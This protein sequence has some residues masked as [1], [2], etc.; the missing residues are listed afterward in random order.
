MN[1]QQHLK[2]LKIGGKI[3]ENELEF[4]TVAQTFANWENPKILVHG[5][6]RKA[7]TVAK[8]L[9]ITPKMHE[10][11][12]ITDDATLEV[13]TMVYAGWM[14]KK[15]VSHLQALGCNALGLSGADLNSIQAHKRIVES[16]DY[17]WAGDI[18]AI[19]TKALLPLLQLAITPVFCAITHDNK[20][21]LLNTNAD[22]IAAYL[23]TALATFYTVQ[24]H[25]C[26]DKA[27]VLLDAADDTS[28]I[29]QINPESYKK[30][31]LEGIIAGGM[32]PKLDNAFA[33][34]DAGVSE[35]VLSGVDNLGKGTKIRTKYNR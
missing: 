7:S 23:A 26:L 15:A 2:I 21:Q 24:L 14:N 25:Y 28:L 19:N 4:G 31:K 12:R 30:Y 6:G 22:T 33:A 20:G 16:I 10:G 17:G 8:R 11:R 27:G 13:V 5:G 3:L 32:L 34:L 9:G 29:E 35:V 18:N 1:K